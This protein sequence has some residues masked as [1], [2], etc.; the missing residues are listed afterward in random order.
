MI[1]R[2]NTLVASSVQSVGREGGTLPVRSFNSAVT[3][4]RVA[5]RARRGGRVL[6]M[7]FL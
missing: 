4:R 1:E 3:V 5:L 7:E 6:V 2:R